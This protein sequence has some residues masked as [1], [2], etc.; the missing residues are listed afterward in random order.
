MS[1]RNVFVYG[2][3]NIM[4]TTQNYLQ[5]SIVTVSGEEISKLKE[6]GYVI[7]KR[8]DKFWSDQNI[9]IDKLRHKVELLI[10]N[11]KTINHNIAAKDESYRY[12]EGTNR[13][14]N[15]LEKDKEFTNLISIPDIIHCTY[16]ILGEN[17]RLSSIGMREP[18]KGAGY[19]GLHLD[20]NQREN[21]NSEFYQIT[22]FILLDNI[23]HSNGPPRIIPKSHNSM[24]NIKSTSSF[25]YK[26]T[27]ADNDNIESQDKSFSISL[28]GNIGDIFLINVN[29][30]HGGS[31]NLDGLR[32]RL[33]HVDYRIK[34]QRAQCDFYKILPKLIH[35]NFTEY[36][37]T[38]LQLYKKSYKESLKRF[39]YRNKNSIIIRILMKLYIYL[40]TY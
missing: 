38:L 18:L 34:S 27:K 13:L 23:T 5:S 19:Q 9:D 8:N 20:W 25:S 30:F 11:S 17:F 4:P 24:I 39:I 33:I 14:S 36:Q 37:K 21:K 40:K 7:L 3:H 26:R 12:E 35:S 16:N 32:R 31:N 10:E 28:T 29:S 22:A 2:L 1:S 6:D 15:L